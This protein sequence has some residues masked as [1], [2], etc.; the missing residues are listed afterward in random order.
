MSNQGRMSGM[1]ALVAAVL[2]T[3]GCEKVTTTAVLV[4]TPP[5]AQV[6][7]EGTVTFTASLPEA[8]REERQLYFPLTWTLADPALGTLTSGAGNTAIYEAGTGTGVNTVIVRDQSGAEGMAAITQADESD[9]G[10]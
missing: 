7:P 6:L 4:V 8:E 10:M 2:L 9:A 5:S 3:V 1:M